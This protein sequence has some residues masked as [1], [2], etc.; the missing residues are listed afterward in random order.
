VTPI[1]TFTAADVDGIWNIT[2][3]T[4]QGPVL[5]Q[6]R[7]VNL[8]DHRPVL[9]SPL[10]YSLDGGNLSIS[11]QASL[12]DSYDQEVCAEGRASGAPVTIPLPRD[13]GELGTIALSP[14]TPFGISTLGVFEPISFWFELYHAYA[15][16]EAGTDNLLADNLMAAQSQPFDLVSN[17][18]TTT[19]LTW[20]EPLRAGRY[21]LRAYF[22]NSTNLEVF[23]SRVLI[24]N[25]SSWV[26]LS[27]S[28]LPQQVQSPGISYSGSLT[29]GQADWP[30]T[31]YYMYRT[32]GV[33][34]VVA[35]PV[36]A[37][38][39]SVN[40]EASPWNGSLQD[41]KVSITSSAGVYQ[42]SQE[43][44]SLFVLASDYPAQLDYSLGI[45]GA[46]GVSQGALTMDER[47]TA[48]T[49]EVSTAELTV[50]LLSNQSSPMTLHVT[51]SHDVNITRGPVGINRTVSIFLPTGSYTVTASQGGVSQS[52]Q[53]DLTDGFAAAVTLNF[54]AFAALE[55][56][57]VVTAA[58]A[59]IAN[60]VVWTLRSR[61]P[62][63]RLSNRPKS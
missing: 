38:I 24:L 53:V 23:Q 59:V 11:A 32:F 15:L 3:A 20:S 21:D 44:S 39:S 17:G 18:P 12:G 10:Q 46:A 57:L 33:E 4:N 63:L 49:L 36:R 37:N 58:I 52:A 54:N 6:V 2:L 14:G 26:S 13:M 5:V 47:Y 41:A 42:T 22:Q 31:L 7:F 55:T 1:H 43:G 62:R 48:Q 56:F 60:V 9:L 8:A 45:G 40:L 27:S 30:R 34:A 25:D 35:F 19:N 51:G 28:C 16:D 50:H 29:T 61:S